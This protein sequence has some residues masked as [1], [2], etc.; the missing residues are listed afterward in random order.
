MG[1][2]KMRYGARRRWELV[3]EMGTGMELGDP[4]GPGKPGWG[5]R[6]SATRHGQRPTPRE[7][8]KRRVGCWRAAGMPR[9]GSGGLLERAGCSTDP[10]TTTLSPPARQSPSPPAPTLRVGPLPVSQRCSTR[11]SPEPF[12]AGQAGALLPARSV[13]SERIQRSLRGPGPQPG[14]CLRSCHC[15][16]KINF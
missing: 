8:K 2:G 4:R 13:G 14:L 15:Q 12:P 16:C 3:A 6:G 1:R 11:S 10:L 7:D 5:S 9:S